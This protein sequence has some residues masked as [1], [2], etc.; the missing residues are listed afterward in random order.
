MRHRVLAAGI[1]GQ[2]LLK[3][4]IIGG[5]LDH[6]AAELVPAD[7]VAP[8]RAGGAVAREL[9][10]RDRGG[11]RGL[12]GLARFSSRPREKERAAPPR[13]EEPPAPCPG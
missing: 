11:E 10:R 13:Q 3:E 6:G 12:P 9:V 7:H 4:P 2:E 8:P 5:E 1:E